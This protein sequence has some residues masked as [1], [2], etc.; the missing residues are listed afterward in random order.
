MQFEGCRKFHTQA[1]SHLVLL[2]VLVLATAGAAAAQVAPP[3]APPVGPYGFVLNARFSHPGL[4]GG[5]ALLGLMTF[6]GAGNVSGTFNLEFGSGGVGQP[7]STTGSLT[8]TYASNLDGTGTMAIVLVDV[9]NVT[10]ANAALAML[11]G[12]RSR[13]IQLVVTGC[14]G[15]ICDLTGSVVSGV[16]EIASSHPVR[17]GFLTGGYGLQ[18]T[19]SSPTPATSLELWAFDGQGGVTRTG[20]FVAPGPSVNSGEILM[21]TYLVNLDGTGTVTTNGKTFAFVVTDGN[22]GLMVLQLHRS[23]D[24]VLY[25]TGHLQ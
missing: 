2:L 13:E 25:G 19:K 12:D 16:A 21:G 15:L 11:M 24:G 17:Q 14:T 23:G 8:G 22:R 7:A 4:E 6:D 9:N 10:L 5:V 18:L 1:F 20:T 3:V